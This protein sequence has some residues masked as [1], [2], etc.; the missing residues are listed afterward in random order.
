MCGDT[1]GRIQSSVSV[2][3]PL[4]LPFA[5]AQDATRT[6]GKTKLA[7]PK[8][9]AGTMRNFMPYQWTLERELKE[10]IYGSLE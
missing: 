2:R 7:E 5:S 4:S 8:V 9:F 6:M 1:A 3:S 10:L